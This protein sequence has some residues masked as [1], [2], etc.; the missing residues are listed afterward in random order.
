MRALHETE[1]T[2]ARTAIDAVMASAPIDESRRDA[3]VEAQTAVVDG[4]QRILDQMSQWESFVDVVNQLRSIIK[5]QDHLLD[6]TEKQQ[7]AR[8]NDVFDE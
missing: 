7:K 1:V 8:V 3:A 2:K 4:M 5:N 6:S